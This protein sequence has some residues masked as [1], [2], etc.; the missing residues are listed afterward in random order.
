M[1]FCLFVCGFGERGL[2]FGDFFFCGF[3]LVVVFCVFFVFVFGVFFNTILILGWMGL[4]GLGF[5][6]CWFV[7]LFGFF[8]LSHF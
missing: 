5:C 7:Y 8:S 6:F 2:L 4:F 3:L 1:G